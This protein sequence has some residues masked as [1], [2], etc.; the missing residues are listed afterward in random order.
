MI[1]VSDSLI[2]RNEGNIQYLIIYYLLLF[3]LL[4][5]W[6]IAFENKQ[7][8]N[9][10]FIFVDDQGYYDLGCYGATEVETPHIDALARM[11]I[12]FTDYYAAAR[13]NTG[14]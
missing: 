6:A 5:S 10:I 4:P 7:G 12:R 3:L 11:G 13:F 9:I 8:P 1:P 14:S 2:K